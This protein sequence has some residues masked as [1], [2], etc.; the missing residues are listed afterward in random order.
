MVVMGAVRVCGGKVLFTISMT[1]CLSFLEVGYLIVMQSWNKEIFAA[2]TGLIG[3]ISGVLIG[4][5]A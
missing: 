4:H 1:V 2:I 3:T 5:K